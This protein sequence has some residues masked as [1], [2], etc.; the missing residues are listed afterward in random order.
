[1]AATQHLSLTPTTSGRTHFS[2]QERDEFVA[3]IQRAHRRSER[4][5]MARRQTVAPMVR[6]PG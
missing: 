6:S 4:R 1:M 5:P 3:A 2:R